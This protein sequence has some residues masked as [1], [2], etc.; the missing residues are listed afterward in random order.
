MEQARWHQIE[1][2]L[3][4]ALDV[5]PAERAA[6]LT[7]ECGTDK[8][9]RHEVDAL[10]RAEA[11][12]AALETPAI[13]RLAPHLAKASRAGD[14]ISHYRIE[15]R[16]GAGGMGEVYQAHDE[17]LKRTVALK[18]LPPEFTTDADRVQRL[19]QE[20]Y[21]ASRLNHPNIITIF[22]I[23]HDR[24]AHCIVTERVEGETL[25]ELLT[26]PQTNASRKLPLEEAL[27]IT[28]QIA[29][30]LKAAHTAWIIH[31]DI[32]PENIMVRSD[33]LVKV[34]DFGIAKLRDETPATRAPGEAVTPGRLTI[35]GAVLGTANYMSPE[36]KRGEALDGRTDLFSLG[37]VLQEMVAAEVPRDLQRMIRKMLQPNRDDRYASAAEL[38]DDLRRLQQRLQS[39]TARR[40][41]GWSAAVVIIALALTA[42]G[43]LLSISET[44]D[45]QVLRD[46]H[47]AASRQ[48]VFSPDGR[49]VVSCGE[50]GQ[51]IVWDFARRERLATLKHSSQKLAFSPDGRWLASGGTD[52]TVIVWETARW[53]AVRILRDHRTQIGAMAFSPDG[54]LLVASSS[55]SQTG[56][57]AWD[58]RNWQRVHRWTEGTTHAA[59]LF[60]P[61]SKQVLS[62]TT[63]TIH[64]L[65]TGRAARA[66]LGTDAA[67]TWMALSR[68]T[69]HLV[70]IDSDGTVLF[71]RCSPA[72]DLRRSELL[73]R[74]R[75]HQ[76]HGRSVA[77]SPD[78]RLVA[79]A[80]DDIVLWD[81]ATQR[82]IARFEHPAIVWSVAFSP[83]GR[84]LISSHG[85]GAVLIWD[86][87]ERKRLANLNGHSGAVRAVAFTP[88]GRR[89]AS[90]GEDQTVIVWD[91]QDG[92]KTAVLI[93]HQ[94]RVTGVSFGPTSN[95]FASGD[96]DGNVMVWD[97]DQRS[98]RRVIKRPYALPAYCVAISPDGRV[99]A[100]TLGMFAFADGRR[101]LPFFDDGW[102]FGHVYGVAFSADSRRLAAATTSGS[103]LLWDTAGRQM[104]GRAE[105]SQTPQITVSLSPDGRW[106]ASGD[107]D[108]I[109]RLWSTAPLRRVAILGRHA[110][111]VKSVA[112]SPDG[113]SVASAGDDKMIA[114]WDV[115]RRRLRARTGTHASPVYSIAFSRDGRRLASGEHDHSVRVYTLRRSLW[116]YAL[117]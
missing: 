61:D 96:Q 101:L 21:A 17:T 67:M 87:A 49:L 33:G 86:V 73:S 5:D 115:K 79:S 77:F 32:K 8:E 117:R 16:I 6:F 94:T 108:G 31:R 62:T 63:S 45:E 107:D 66:N 3:Q 76:D 72:G 114:L 20:A 2:L 15:N 106:L 58:S 69:A 80:A 24:G 14:R 39:R 74:W 38:L 57:I 50:D 22:E 89:V 59:I 82:K 88:D 71:Y 91:L 40:M 81:V 100:S 116:G 25:R 111:R 47:Q 104:I 1:E 98:Q 83:D 64:D 60:S 78:G 68:D 55:D 113:A 70:G 103:V 112:F 85:D 51:V 53:K 18:L 9:L 11:S 65:S 92:R 95:Q 12:G 27:D 44:W 34:V 36:Q 52:G 4:S 97:I 102:R 109:V 28:I 110:A 46:G 30:A 19:E 37:L 26:D 35:A 43:A 105:A 29:A 93:G 41:V 90:G 75:A 10:L 84:W 7:R 99:V 56:T 23:V 48:A 13:V 54:R 42:A